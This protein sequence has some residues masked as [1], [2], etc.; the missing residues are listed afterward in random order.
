MALY[1]GALDLIAPH[2][3]EL[4]VVDCCYVQLKSLCKASIST[5]DLT[6]HPTAIRAGKK[7]DHVGD[8]LWFAESFQWGLFS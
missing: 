2:Y 3:R 4:L 7:G 1:V 6:I 5:D 8:I